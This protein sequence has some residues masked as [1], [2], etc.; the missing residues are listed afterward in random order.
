MSDAIAD[1]PP[2]PV[3]MLNE[4]T[5]CARLGYLMWVQGEWAESADTLDGQFVHRNVDREDRRAAPAPTAVLDKAKDKEP[6]K[7]AE[8][9]VILHARS[10]RLEDATL[11]M[12]AVADIVELEGNVAT[13]VDYKRAK[14]PDIPEGAWEPD[15]VQLCGQALLLRAAGYQ[16]DSGIVYYAASKK[17]VPVVF[18]DALVARTMSLL[19]EFR[20]VAANGKMPLPLVDSPKCPRCSLISIC[21]PDETRILKEIGIE[22]IAA[23]FAEE[24]AP[25]EENKPATPNGRRTILVPR[26]D[27]RPLHISEPGA[28]LGKTGERLKVELKEKELLTVRLIDVSQV[29][30]Y[31]PVQVSTQALTELIDADIPVCYFSSGGWF[32]GISTG[33][34]HKN[35]EIRIRQYAIAADPKQSLVFAKSFVTGKIRN[36][37]TLLR[38]NLPDESGLVLHQLVELADEADKATSIETLLGYEGMAAKLYFAAFARLMKS[39]FDFDGRNRRP[40]TDPVNATLSFLYAMLAKECHIAAQIAGLDPMLGLLHQP[41]YGRPSLALDLAEEFRP[42]LADSVALSLLNTGELKAEHFVRRAAAC[43]LTATGRRTVVTAWERRLRSEVT[44]PIFGYSL[45]YS[46]VIP[47]QARL[48]TRALI[49]EI[50]IYPSFKT[51]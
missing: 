16:C 20:Q 9:E 47:V 28:R 32:R 37:R 17:R 12:I 21:M 36:C 49:G 6:T 18:D 42:L 31:G 1:V 34:S 44:H 14:A 24:F 29:C 41:R 46:R 38:R 8:P 51:R 22:G 23:A 5:Y 48:L 33:F 50:P 39:E 13:P 15:R 45:S 2:V 40:P 19:A 7:D 10:L 26:A 35:I 3:R 30:L 43:A 4:Y 27:A 25:T 11:G